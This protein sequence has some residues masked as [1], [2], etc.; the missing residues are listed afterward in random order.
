[1]PASTT[2]P[3]MPAECHHRTASSDNVRR[4]DVRKDGTWM[5]SLPVLFRSLEYM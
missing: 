4:A 5:A 2:R 1:M 3:C